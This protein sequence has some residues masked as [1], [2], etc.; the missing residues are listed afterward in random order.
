MLPTIS[1]D[2][3]KVLIYL[4]EWNNL[5]ELVYYTSGLTG[6][7]SRCPISDAVTQA[8]WL[9]Q[10]ESVMKILC[11]HVTAKKQQQPS[12]WSVPKKKHWRMPL[13]QLI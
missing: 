6:P 13:Y 4:Y 3:R 7:R 2:I 12:P 11:F 5:E 10:I 9:P 8:S 1:R